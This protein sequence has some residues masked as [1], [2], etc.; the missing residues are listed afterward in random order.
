[1]IKIVD[2]FNSYNFIIN[3]KLGESIMKGW[4]CWNVSFESE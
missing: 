4:A 2:L 3:T 1:M